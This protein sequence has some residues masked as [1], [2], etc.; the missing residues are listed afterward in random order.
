MLL[1]IAMFW[2]VSTQEG[3]NTTAGFWCSYLPAEAT[4]TETY[5]YIDPPRATNGKPEMECMTVGFFSIHEGI[6]FCG[7]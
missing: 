1:V 6:L 3:K 7:C 2:L 4:V 5:V